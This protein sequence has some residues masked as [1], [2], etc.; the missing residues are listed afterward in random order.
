MKIEF[1]FQLHTNQ[2]F[3]VIL[4]T[5]LVDTHVKTDS[6]LSDTPPRRYTAVLQTILPCLPSY[7]FRMVHEVYLSKQNY[8]ICFSSKLSKSGWVPGFIVSSTTWYI[9][10]IYRFY[11]NVNRYFPTD[12][13]DAINEGSKD[14]STQRINSLSI[15]F[16]SP[17]QTSTKLSLWLRVKGFV[18]IFITLPFLI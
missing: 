8:F 3:A 2:P 9:I 1:C 15:W 10:N 16:G 5:E 7:I 17:N 4:V 12:F 11:C 18:L 14:W 13:K 6:V